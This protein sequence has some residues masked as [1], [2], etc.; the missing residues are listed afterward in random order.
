MQVPQLSIRTRSTVSF[1]DDNSILI[2]FR[3]SEGLKDCPRVGHHPRGKQHLLPCRPPKSQLT[4]L[5][6]FKTKSHQ[7]KP[8][9]T[10][11][12]EIIEGGL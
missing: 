5:T 4:Q 8:K 3:Q 6:E 12:R 10:K 1:R 9:E 7:K 11:R 2:E